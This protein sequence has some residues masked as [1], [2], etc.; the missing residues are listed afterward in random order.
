MSGGNCARSRPWWRLMA[1]GELTADEILDHQRQ[2]GTEK[3]GGWRGRGHCLGLRRMS[4]Y[5]DV[6]YPL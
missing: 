2:R 3:A 5:P 1:D 4:F 6:F